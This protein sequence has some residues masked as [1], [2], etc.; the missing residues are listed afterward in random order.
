VAW[1]RAAPSDARALLQGAQQGVAVA[2]S[3]WLAVVT[4]LL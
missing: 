3:L 4:R 1:R 2:W